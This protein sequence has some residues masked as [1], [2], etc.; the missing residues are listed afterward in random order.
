M[1]TLVQ[2]D[3]SIMEKLHLQLP[4][5]KVGYFFLFSFIYISF[6]KTFLLL[7]ESINKKY[8]REILI[9]FSLLLVLAEKGGAKFRDYSSIDKAPE[10]RAR[11]ITIN[12][13]HVEY[14]T[15][16]R[17]YS[18]VDCPGH[19]DYVKNMITGASQMVNITFFLNLLQKIIKH[20]RTQRKKRQRKISNVKLIP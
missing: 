20:K 7:I 5:P 6:R 2:L 16:K 18:H 19:A 10:E 8:L 11:G 4:L 1:S 14:E 15:E 13:S 9:F 12:S 17:H 3:M